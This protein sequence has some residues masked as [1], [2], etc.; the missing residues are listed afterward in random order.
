MLLE[1]VVE[2]LTCPTP[3]WPRRVWISSFGSAI[4]TRPLPLTVSMVLPLKTE[5]PALSWPRCWMII[6]AVQS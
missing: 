3:T 2:Y 6:R 1:P 5:I 4:V